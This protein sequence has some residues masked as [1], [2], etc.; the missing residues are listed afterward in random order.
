MPH[1]TVRVS[2]R[3]ARA[4]R[5]V[6]DPSSSRR[7]GWTRGSIL[8]LLLLVSATMLMYW[9]VGTFDYVLYDDNTYV[10]ANPVV[11]GG[12]TR[13]G[14]TWAFTRVHASNWHP[15]SWLSHMLDVQLFGKG[16]AWPHRMNLLLHLANTVLLAAALAALTGAPRLGV[17][18]AG[19]FA[20]HPL[21]VESVAWVSERKD[22]LS[23]LFWMLSLLAYTGFVRRRTP[24]RYLALVLLFGCGLLAKQMVV[25]LPFVLL[26]LDYWPLGRLGT[27]PRQDQAGATIRRLGH[28]ALE[29]LPLLAMAAAASMATLHAQKEA[30]FTQVPFL[31]RATNAALSLVLYL[32]KIFAPAGLTA[33]YP[34]LPGRQWAAAGAAALLIVGCTAVALLRGRRY[35]FFP[36]GWF[37]YLGTLVP[38]LGLVQVGGQAMADRY[39]YLPSVGIFVALSWGAASISGGRRVLARGLTA[40]CVALL[41]LLLAAGKRQVGVWENSGTLFAHGL[42]V[43]PDDWV[44]HVNLAIFLRQGGRP[45]EAI[46][47][48][49]EALRIRHGRDEIAAEILYN[50]ANALASL[51]RFDEAITYYREAISLKPGD[52]GYHTN[53]AS[54]LRR[55]GQKAAA[56]R[57]LAEARRLSAPTG[58]GR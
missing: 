22:V 6:A 46:P 3:S 58:T 21:H 30:L 48:Y 51:Q 45:A 20:L 53:L 2:P 5:S 34:L 47:H 36:A 38:V 54:A 8:L 1:E 14:I 56:A 28:L 31:D 42:R 23:S 57:H 44:A 19:L 7:R 4:G 50:L 24:G 29:K 35:P 52:P 13:E 25:T 16:P 32:V 9:D 49:R 27:A 10:T 37:W 33:Y 12:V 43:N 26:L 11:L 17:A 55:S 41:G 39:T 15:L 18:A 40:V